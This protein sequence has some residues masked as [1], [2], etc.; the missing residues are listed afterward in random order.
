MS[1]D[2]R[3]EITISTSLDRHAVKELMLAFCPEDEL[4]SASALELF[5][6]SV[7]PSVVSYWPCKTIGSLPHLGV[8]LSGFVSYMEREGLMTRVETS[9][10]F[11]SRIL[12]LWSHEEVEAGLARDS[13][14]AAWMFWSPHVTAVVDNELPESSW[15]NRF[16]RVKLANSLYVPEIVRRF[17][18]QSIPFER[19][20]MDDRWEIE[21][22]D[23]HS[24]YPLS[25]G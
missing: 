23:Q 20:V 7:W 15:S 3:C 11:A 2:E 12:R 22:T 1:I 9:L 17:E 19:R 25:Q 16:E 13:S 18:E 5:D 6:C 4:L 24:L 10:Y 21:E 8:S 14:Y